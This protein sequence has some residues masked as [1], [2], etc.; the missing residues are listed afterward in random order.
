MEQNKERKFLTSLNGYAVYSGDKIYRIADKK[1]VTVKDVVI[2]EYNQVYFIIEEK[3]ESVFIEECCTDNNM[4][5][6][7][8]HID[9]YIDSMTGFSDKPKDVIRMEHYSKFFF[10]LHR[11]PAY[12]KNDFAEW[13]NQYKLLC[14]YN[15]K[16]YRVT[17]CSRMGDIWLNENFNADNGYDHRVMINQVSDFSME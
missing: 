16:K 6:E 2:S 14:K 7:D 15:G 17:G 3:D 13:I 1:L 5:E 10:L 8:K 4:L 9:N 11:L 12:M